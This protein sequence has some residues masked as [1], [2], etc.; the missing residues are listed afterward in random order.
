MS[1]IPRTTWL[2]LS[3]LT[4]TSLITAFTFS[5]SRKG[6]CSHQPGWGLIR[7]ISCVA[8]ATMSI[9]SVNSDI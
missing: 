8:Q 2:D 9:K 5:N 4:R 7:G 3:T 6:S 1:Y